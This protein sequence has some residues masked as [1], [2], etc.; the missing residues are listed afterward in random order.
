MNLTQLSFEHV[1]LCGISFF[2]LSSVIFF[3]FNPIIK[4]SSGDSRFMSVTMII[5]CTWTQTTARKVAVSQC[6]KQNEWSTKSTH[7]SIKRLQRDTKHLLSP[8]SYFK[9]KCKNKWTFSKLHNSLYTL[10]NAFLHCV[11]IF[12]LHFVGVPCHYF[13]WHEECWFLR[14]LLREVVQRWSW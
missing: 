14:S 6:K 9:I 10:K 8:S 1:N 4:N 2:C 7:K 3:I 11:K 5:P 12:E 13:P